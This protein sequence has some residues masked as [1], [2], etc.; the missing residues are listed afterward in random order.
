[1]QA[2][3]VAPAGTT[4][5]HLF[6]GYTWWMPDG[7]SGA[8][9]GGDCPGH[10]TV[11]AL[12]APSPPPPPPPSPPPPTPPPPT[13]P[14]PSPSPKP[15]PPAS[16]PPD[17]VISIDVDNDGTVELS[18]SF[19]TAYALYANTPAR[20]VFSGNHIVEH[21]DLAY[22]SPV[23]K[24]CTHPP[25][26]PAL[27]GFVGADASITVSPPAGTWQL[28]L[29]EFDSTDAHAAA[30]PHVDFRVTAA[31]PPPSPP[32]P[33][34]PNPPPP[35]PPPSPP[36]PPP[37]PHLDLACI[38]GRTYENMTFS[39]TRIR[40]FSG[41]A[42]PAEGVTACMADP[43][44][45]VVT[46]SE[47]ALGGTDTH[48]FV[49]RRANGAM[50]A[51]EGSTSYMPSPQCRPPP[52]PP[53]S[54]PSPP[55][56]T[57]ATPSLPPSTLLAC[58]QQPVLSEMGWTGEIVGPDYD[59]AEEAMHACLDF[60]NGSCYAVTGI[61]AT[62][63]AWHVRGR[64][65][66]YPSAGAV[67]VVR[68]D[69]EAS[70]LRPLPPPSPPSPPPSP[71]TAAVSFD[72]TVEGDL[73]EFD[74]AAYVAAMAS[75]LGVPASA[76]GVSASAGSVIVATTI[77]TDDPDAL[78]TAVSETLGSPEAASAALGMAVADVSAPITSALVIIA[79]PAP[80]LPP[81]HHHKDDS[82]PVW[83]IIAIVLSAVGL[84]VLLG[85]CYLWEQ[86]RTHK[87]HQAIPQEDKFAAK[88]GLGP[89]EQTFYGATPYS[90]HTPQRF[91]ALNS[92]K[93]FRIKL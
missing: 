21:F 57:P 72:V 31:P 91:H 63:G 6:N 35:P 36:K 38:E 54:P 53:P 81:P 15:P 77:A 23:G 64:G 65:V 26:P 37:V 69:P 60:T 8:Q 76:I 55:P 74:E 11:V 89:G 56:P 82:F 22:L 24:P 25:I 14:P 68:A 45:A 1:M 59:S 33:I 5:T 9:H 84:V 34:S 40:G 51:Q 79:P 75:A 16:P 90:L 17:I 2:H 88:N 86:K 47:F 66:P 20:L 50:V 18:T 32:P 70:C 4:H 83:A 73:S 58:F 19:S 87:G 30:H 12:V 28:C 13:P 27:G 39:G 80:P 85:A 44:C 49:L 3:N 52:S 7:F 48:R 78:A 93:D 43:D 42:D 61:A 67:L 62:D 41:A 29:R 92:K 71:Y 46:R 10:S